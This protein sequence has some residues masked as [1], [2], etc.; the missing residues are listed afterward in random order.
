MNIKLNKYLFYILVAFYGCDI[1]ES[2]IDENITPATADPG[3][4]TVINY[5]YQLTDINPLSSSYNE[6]IG[7]GLFTDQITVHYFGHQN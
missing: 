5:D 3:N 6:L 7:N 4:T 2:D 1:F